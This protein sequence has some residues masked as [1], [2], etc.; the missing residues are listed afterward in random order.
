MAYIEDVSAT[1]FSNVAVQRASM[2]AHYRKEKT[3]VSRFVKYTLFFFN[4]FIML[5]GSFVIGIG[6]YAIHAG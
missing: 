6:G 3:H 5:I 4:F 1:R 2:A